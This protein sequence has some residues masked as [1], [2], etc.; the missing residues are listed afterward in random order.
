[1]TAGGQRS[2]LMP[3][4]EKTCSQSSLKVGGLYEHY[5]GK[6]YRVHGTVKHSE[7]LEEMV[8]YETL[9]ENELGKMW[10]RPKDMFLE[11]IELN[12]KSIPRFRLVE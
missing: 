9:Y 8:L 3:M 12:G 5:K 11:F 1:L 7:S 6:R 2:Y 10:V 4:N